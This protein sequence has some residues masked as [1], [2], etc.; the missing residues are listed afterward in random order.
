[1]AIP[2]Q[3]VG[4]FSCF[5]A[6]LAFVPAV[7]ILL[8]PIIIIWGGA[9]WKKGGSS[10]VHIGFGGLLFNIVLAI[11]LPFYQQFPMLG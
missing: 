8:A 9:T 3:K 7:G 4:R 5:L 2:D 10:I 1:M 6:Y 11:C